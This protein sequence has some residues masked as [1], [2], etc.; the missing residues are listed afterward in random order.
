MLKLGGIRVD[1]DSI[2]DIDALPATLDL[3]DGCGVKASFFVAMGPDKT[4]K[5]LFKYLKRPWDLKKARPSRFGFLNLLRG[6]IGPELME[7]HKTEL[8]G[9]EKRGHEVGLHGYGHYRWMN[10]CGKKS[11]GDI[12]KGRAIFEDVFK[13]APRSFASPG[14]FVNNKILRKIDG[15]GFDYSSD[16]IGDEPFYPTLMGERFNTLQVPVCIK[17]IGEFI[18]EGLGE[19]RIFDAY[20]QEL[21]KRRFFTFYFHPSYEVKTSMELLDKVIRNLKEFTEILT[22]AEIAG[23][24]KNENIADL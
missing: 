13:C 17:S 6:L 12:E 4:G 9:I 19:G 23:K 3:L 8:R 20:M 2:G 11:A 1:I 14:F 15:A 24:W 7:E 22:F 5:N 10:T 16:F 18:A 21:I